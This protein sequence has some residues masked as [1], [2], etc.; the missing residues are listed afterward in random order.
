MLHGVVE[1]YELLASEDEVW[2]ECFVVVAHSAVLS[3]YN[4]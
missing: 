2:R 4:A 1:L 3:G